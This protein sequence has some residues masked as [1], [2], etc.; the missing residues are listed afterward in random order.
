MDGSSEL[1]L[2]S[3]DAF[4]IIY[5]SDVLLKPTRRSLYLRCVPWQQRRDS[6]W[7]VDSRI[8]FWYVRIAECD[9]RKSCTPSDRVL[10]FGRCEWVCLIHS[11]DSWVGVLG[12]LTRYCRVSC[13]FHIYFFFMCVFFFNLFLLLLI[14][15]I[16][17]KEN[18]EIL[19]KNSN[20]LL[21]F[22]HVKKKK[23]KKKK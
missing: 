9:R 19:P 11:S 20:L 23:K 17:Y 22:F 7:L 10:S 1:L 6:T 4:Y 8:I 5:F 16:H 3:Y 12:T 2:V 21:L 13:F 15:F 14:I 18:N